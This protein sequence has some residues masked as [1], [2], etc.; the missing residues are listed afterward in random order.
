MAQDK[1]KQT[2]TD[3]MLEGTGQPGELA[4]TPTVPSDMQDPVLVGTGQPGELMGAPD[5]PDPGFAKADSLAKR[6]AEVEVG[7]K[8]KW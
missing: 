5:T 8:R 2:M 6:A 7:K 1:M 4:D 3:P